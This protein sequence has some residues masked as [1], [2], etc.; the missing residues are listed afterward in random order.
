ME[1]AAPPAAAAPPNATIEYTVY[2][3]ADEIKYTPEHALQ[4]GLK[5]VNKL[6]SSIQTLQLGPR[7]KEVWLRDTTRF[8]GSWHSLTSFV[9]FRL[10]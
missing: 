2:K 10:F 4:H 5:M 6:A 3:S 9:S 1:D 8:A 7:R